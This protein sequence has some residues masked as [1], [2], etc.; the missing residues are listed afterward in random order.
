M[1]NTG[2]HLGVLVLLTSVLGTGCATYEPAPASDVAYQ[3]RAISETEGDVTA[4]V[5]A[6]SAEEADRTFGLPLSKQ[7][8]QPVWI[9]VENR[10]SV[11]YVFLPISVD[12]VYYSPYEVAFHNRSGLSSSSRKAMERHLYTQHMPI[13][14][15]ASSVRSGFVYTRRDKGVKVINVMLVSQSQPRKVHLLDFIALVPG[16][17]AD[18][19]KVDR[20]T[21][22]AKD[23][24]RD[25][26][27]PDELRNAIEALPCCTIGP[28]GTTP[29]DPA[30]VVLIG[31]GVDVF[32]ALARRGWDITEIENND[33]VSQTIG[34]SL[35]GTRYHHSP[36]SP[37]W[38]F[39]RPQDLGLQK[40]RR[41]VDKRNHMRLWLAP[42]R[43]RGDDVYVGQISRDI[44]VKFSSKTFVTHEIDPDVDE[45]RTYLLQDL[46]FSQSVATGGYAGGVGAASVDEPRYNYTED[47]YFTDGK[48]IVLVIT[49]GLRGLEEVQNFGWK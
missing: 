20:E 3:Q 1:T 10:S 48:R 7:E 30:N 35:F 33:S 37:L 4:S 16:L 18:Y 21:L 5:V 43:Y 29:G 25:I 22:Y 47:A 2:R 36:I 8:V 17:D 40:A 9:R 49:H 6:L 27:D 12:P 46:L 23:E 15:P 41:T 26:T 44:G 32:A 28:D 19:T 31:K 39:G 45:T 38:Y 13:D 24:Y 14:I 42:L 34:S 11:P